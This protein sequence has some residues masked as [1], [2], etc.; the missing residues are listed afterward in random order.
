VLFLSAP[1]YAAWTINSVTIAEGDVWSIGDHDVVPITVNLTGDGSAE[2]NLDIWAQLKTST[3]PMVQ[4]YYS[5][6]NKGSGILYEVEYY[7]GSDAPDND[8]TLTIYSGRLLKIFTSTID[9]NE[10]GQGRTG[11]VYGGDTSEGFKPGVHRGLT[12]DV[13]DIGASG[14]DIILIFNILI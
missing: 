12:I 13:G 3:D 10:S 5:K 9:Y 8:F 2:T 4:S 11:G 1:V 14:D 6:L 7:Q